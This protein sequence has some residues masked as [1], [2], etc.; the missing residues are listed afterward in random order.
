[1]KNF[2]KNNNLE[3]SYPK[4]AIWRLVLVVVFFLILLVSVFACDEFVEVDLPNSQLIADGVFEEK[5]TANAAMTHIYSKIRD[6]GLLTGSTVGLSHLLGNYADELDFYGN[7]QIAASAFYNNVLI[8]SNSDVKNLWSN[9][10]NQIYAANA[11]IEGVENSVKLASIERD[12]LKG[13]ALFVRALIHFYLANIFDAVPY[14]STT[15]YEENKMVSR[16][17]VADVYNNCITDLQE[18]MQLL[19]ENY[20]AAYRVRPNKFAVHALLARVNLYAGFWEQAANQATIII[21]NSSQYTYETDLSKTF[22][23]QSMATIWQL[24]PG[25]SGGNTLESETFNFTVGPP[26]MSA[27]T[28]SLMTAFSANDLRKVYWTKAVTDGASIW[29]H[30]FKYKASNTGSSV[31]YSIIFRLAEMYL[32]RAEARAHTGNL[33]GAKQDLDNIRNAAGL[34]NT[35]AISQDQ[36]LEAILQERQLELFAELGHR[37]FDLKRF[38]KANEVLSAAKP[39]WEAYDILFPIPESELNLNSNLQPQN[40]GY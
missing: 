20:V 30:P 10:Y 18:A 2:N 36:I 35:I 15:N 19:P 34:S 17:S 16:V 4:N 25:F 39:G 7:S 22:L 27:L 26:P 6:V 13:E 5:T 37:F 8:P 38:N 24:A 23:K 14:I 1:M 31:E 28:A 12:Q 33:T 32:I 9:S 29:Y 40:L 11:V 3:N 21:N